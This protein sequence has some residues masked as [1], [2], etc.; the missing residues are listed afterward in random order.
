MNN[1]KYK[2]IKYK[3]LYLNL[4]YK[5]GGK[6][7]NIND[8][9]INDERINDIVNGALL[10][11]TKNKDI[12]K[13]YDNINYLIKNDLFNSEYYIPNFNSKKKSHKI[14]YLLCNYKSLCSIKTEKGTESKNNKD[15]R[16][17]VYNLFNILNNDKIRD[18]ITIEN[19][20]SINDLKDFMKF[21]YNI[22]YLKYHIDNFS[23]DK[24]ILNEQF[25]NVTL[26]PNNYITL[27]NIF[28]NIFEIYY[29][30]LDVK[31][32]HQFILDNKLLNNEQL[33]LIFNNLINNYYNKYKINTKDK[34]IKLIYLFNEFMRDCIEKICSNFCL[35]YC[36][37]CVDINNEKII[38]NYNKYQ[39]P[40][41]NIYMK[42]ETEL[43][44]LIELDNLIYGYNNL[45]NKYNIDDNDKLSDIFEKFDTMKDFEMNINDYNTYNCYNLINFLIY[46]NKEDYVKIKNKNE[47]KNLF[48][49]F[50]TEQLKELYNNIIFKKYIFK[51]KNILYIKTEYKY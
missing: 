28:K 17:L 48:D 20:K 4:K 14:L 33:L 5:K 13:L 25:S 10:T 16:Y 3:T 45:I 29:I 34:I 24:K 39:K 43:N 30:K 38:N 23:K 18:K 26:L 27:Q 12:Q 2:Y 41:E 8:E 19:L 6:D 37:K 46:L 1:Y 44:K 7:K 31:I 50:N 36:Y 9:R 49:F 21:D 11:L 22:N 40:Y 51:D 15:Y 47:N 42:L 35:S 32:M